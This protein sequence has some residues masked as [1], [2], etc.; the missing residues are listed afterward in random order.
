MM[1]KSRIALVVSAALAAP[2]IA[3]ATNG[4]NLEGYGPIATG[5]GGAS[6]A[7]DN[8]TAAMM[9][10]PATL[11]LA[12]EGSRLDIAVGVLSPDIAVSRTGMTDAD[13]DATQFVMPAIG[14]VKNNGKMGYG[15]G[16]FAQGGMGTEYAGD[17]WMSGGTGLENY[18]EV[19]VGRMLFPFTYK[20]NDAV[21]FGASIDYVWAGMDLQMMMAGSTMMDMMPTTLNPGAS[22]YMGTMGGTL[23]N[24]MGN[25]IAGG[26]MNASNPL[27]YGYFDFKNSSPYTGEAM[28]TGFAGKIG[29]TFQLSDKLTIGATYH[30]KTAMSDLEASGASV[31]FNANMD[32]NVLDGSYTTA[33][34][35]GTYTAATIGMTGD[36]AVVDFQW[37]STMGLGVAYQATDKL[38]VVA[39]VKKVN[40]SEVMDTFKVKFTPDS[41]QSNPLAQ[42]FVDMGGDVMNVSMNQQWDDQTV[43]SVGASYD[44]TD[45]MTVRAG[46]NTSSNPV[47]DDYLNP[48][49]PATVE[50]HMTVGLGVAMS[51]TASID[52]SVVKSSTADNDITQNGTATGMSVS[53]SQMNYQ[54]MFSKKF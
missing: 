2:T 45:A 4:M 50:T 53:H 1:K 46:Y 27:N 40:W 21:N 48:L 36:I 43:V 17:T 44:V 37:P 23:V 15:F 34:M 3:H 35:A 47:P 18:S 5:M 13:S 39:D 31:S 24:T 38:K 7:Y 6:M 14:W 12:D 42:A 10:N 54:V 11:G 19:G 8:G 52:I 28:G 29:M 22:N 26:M 20:I 30:S 32:D 51:D 41:T 49:F 16:V 33:G 9:N 25:A